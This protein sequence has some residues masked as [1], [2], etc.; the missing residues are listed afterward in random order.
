MSVEE[1]NK[2][3]ASLGL[4]PLEVDSPAPKPSQQGDEISLS[5]EE[6]NKLRAKLGLPPLEETAAPADSQATAEGTVDAEGY[7]VIDMEKRRR[8]EEIRAKL[9]QSRQRRERESLAHLQGKGLGDILSKEYQNMSLNDWVPFIKQEKIDRVVGAERGE[10]GRSDGG[11]GPRSGG[12]GGEEIGGNEGGGKSVGGN[13]SRSRE[14]GFRGG[15]YGFD[16]ASRGKRG[17][18]RVGCAAVRRT[19]QSRGSGGRAG[20]RG[21]GNRGKT[22]GTEPAARASETP[23]VGKPGNWDVDT[24]AMTTTSSIPASRP[25]TESSR[26]TTRSEPR[27]SSM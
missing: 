3:R 13:E 16:A 12:R 4:P 7:V 25:T 21:A 17:N 18:S 11:A 20:E 26:S 9:E 22:E 19:G 24:R 5:V 6:T 1:T 15:R 10:A 27:F 2:L 23:D 8:E 14:D